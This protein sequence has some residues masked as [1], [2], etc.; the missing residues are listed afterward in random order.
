MYLELAACQDFSAL[1][2]KKVG[3]IQVKGLDSLLAL[4]EGASQQV[5][6]DAGISNLHYQVK[7]LIDISFLPLLE[8]ASK[9]LISLF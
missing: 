8:Y 7:A 5:S 2:E 4:T 1:Y 9:D 6:K 3:L